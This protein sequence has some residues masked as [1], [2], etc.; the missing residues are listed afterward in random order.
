MHRKVIQETWERL[1]TAYAAGINFIPVSFSTNSLA[2]SN[3][4]LTSS[5]GNDLMC[6]EVVEISWIGR[7]VARIVGIGIVV[8]HCVQA[9]VIEIRKRKA[10]TGVKE[11]V[12]HKVV[13]E[14]AVV[15]IIGIEPIL[16]AHV[17]VVDEAPVS[18]VGVVAKQIAI[19]QL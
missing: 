7:V 14:D 17:K 9:E 6:G 3:W 19:G 16:V 15:S 5:N 12:G 2:L 11:M 10:R 1:K 8:E 13:E 4:R 18:Q